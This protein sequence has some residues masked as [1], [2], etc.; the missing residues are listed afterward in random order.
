MCHF[1]Q[2]KHIYIF[3]KQKLQQNHLLK[4]KLVFFI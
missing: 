1:A 4:K 2:E 3:L